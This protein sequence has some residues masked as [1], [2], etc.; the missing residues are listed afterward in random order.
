MVSE[1]ANQ[2]GVDFKIDHKMSCEIESFKAAYIMRNFP[3]TIVYNDVADLAEGAKPNPVEGGAPTSFGGRVP[4]PHADML[5]A[6]RDHRRDDRCSVSCESISPFDLLPP[7][8]SGHVVQGLLR[9]SDDDDDR[10]LGEQGEERRD[11]PR[12]R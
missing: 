2:R 8:S 12:R 6:V 11:L 7:P 10:A 5:I 3:N 9:A 1:T 4:V